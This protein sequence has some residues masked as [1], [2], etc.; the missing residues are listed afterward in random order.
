MLAGETRAGF[1]QMAQFII[2][3]IEEIHPATPA[4]AVRGRP[5]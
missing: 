1:A 5:K 4:S 3:V 2:V